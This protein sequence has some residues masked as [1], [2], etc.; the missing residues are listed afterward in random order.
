MYYLEA[1]DGDLIN[2]D[3]LHLISP[4]RRIPGEEPWEIR[5][6]VAEARYVPIYIGPEE[7]CQR[8]WAQIKERTL[9]P[10]PASFES[11]LSGF[12]GM[13]ERYEN[14]KPL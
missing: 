6:W 10:R 9:A 12:E 2:L 11:F 7:D 4:P 3:R 8:F 13:L 1:P 5:A 14:S